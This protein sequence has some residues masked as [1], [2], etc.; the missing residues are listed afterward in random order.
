M[1][2][3]TKEDIPVC[4]QLKESGV[5]NKD[6]AAY[7]GVRPE[8]FSI[9]INHPKTENQTQLSNALK[10]AEAKAKVEMLSKIQA[11]GTN[12][13]WQAAAWWLERKYPEEFGRPEA[14]FARQIAKEAQEAADKRF[15]EVLVTIKEK[16]FENRA[17]T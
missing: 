11:A 13:N 6:I 10:K 2:K 15:D 14:Q 5:N 9:W 3:L 17:D 7:I 8:T 12:G 1:E 16:A 4:V